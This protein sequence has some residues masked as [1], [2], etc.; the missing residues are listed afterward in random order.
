MSGRG[1]WFDEIFIPGF[2][3]AMLPASIVAAAAVAYASYEVI[4][5]ADDPQEH[6]VELDKALRN[7]PAGNHILLIDSSAHSFRLGANGDHV[8]YAIRENKECA[9]FVTGDPTKPE[10]LNV[11]TTVTGEISEPVCRTIG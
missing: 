4:S 3:I 5:R 6:T 1:G 9:V 2:I 11:A 7:S 10:D 8:R